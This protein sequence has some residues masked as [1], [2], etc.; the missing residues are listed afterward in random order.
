MGVD[1]DK[2]AQL[3]TGW[4]RLLNALSLVGT[5][6]SIQFV[7]RSFFSLVV[8]P[9]FKILNVCCSGGG[10]VFF[11]VLHSGKKFCVIQ[12]ASNG[13][14]LIGLKLRSCLGMR[15]T[16]FS[17]SVKHVRELEVFIH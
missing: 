17:H 14:H 10:R 2:F 4:G 12:R 16:F 9:N 1:S 7:K 6:K 15:T 5:Q 13:E 11:C 3:S 8:L